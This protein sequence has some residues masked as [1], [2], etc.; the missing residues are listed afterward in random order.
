[1]YE[2]YLYK[3]NQKNKELIVDNKEQHLCLRVY[4]FNYRIS[5]ISD[6]SLHYISM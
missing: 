4:N 6:C 3:V 1:M 2:T 5:N